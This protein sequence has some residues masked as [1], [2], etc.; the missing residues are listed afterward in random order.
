MFT[1]FSSV[2]NRRGI[3]TEQEEQQKTLTHK[4]HYFFH[5]SQCYIKTVAK[6]F[7]DIHIEIVQ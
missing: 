3:A 7:Y 2:P 5:S 6:L 1:F 4:Y